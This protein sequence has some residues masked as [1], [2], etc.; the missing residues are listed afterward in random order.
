MKQ[1]S[2]WFHPLR[3]DLSCWR[4]VA[5][6]WDLDLGAPEPEFRAFSMADMGQPVGDVG[7]VGDAGD[8]GMGQTLKTVEKTGHFFLHRSNPIALPSPCQLRLSLCPD[9]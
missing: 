7:D 5:F 8:V 2:Q 9:F 1:A 6:C 3:D 4:L